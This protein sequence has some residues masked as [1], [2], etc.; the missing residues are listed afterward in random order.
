[1]IFRYIPKFNFVWCFWSATFSITFLMQRWFMKSAL[2]E[3]KKWK[4]EI[5]IQTQIQIQ[6]AHWQREKDKWKM[7]IQGSNVDAGSPDWK[8]RKGGGEYIYMN[9]N[10]IENTN[11]NHWKS[12]GE[13]R[14]VWNGNWMRLCSS[15]DEHRKYTEVRFVPPVTPS[16]SVKFLPAG[17]FLQKHFFCVRLLLFF[18]LNYKKKE[19]V[20]MVI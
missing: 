15:T 4:M 19:D 18:K 3:G 17:K 6:R 16:E 11:T 13:W 14:G 7:E 2:G 10:K 5:Q 8:S 1:M 20:E 9:T 12:I